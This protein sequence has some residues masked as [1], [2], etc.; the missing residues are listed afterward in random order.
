VF[1]SRDNRGSWEH[2]QLKAAAG[3]GGADDLFGFS[4]DDDAEHSFETPS[5]P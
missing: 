1:F 4:V 5:G 3:D 2:G